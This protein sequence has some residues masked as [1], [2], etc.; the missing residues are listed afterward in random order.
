MTTSKFFARRTTANLGWD[1]IGIISSTFQ[2]VWAVWFLLPFDA[3]KIILAFN[4]TT[5]EN[6]WAMICLFVGF[7]H[8]YSIFS[9]SLRFRKIGCGLAIMFWTSCLVI[10][11]QQTLSSAIIPMYTTINVYMLVNLVWLFSL[12]KFGEYGRQ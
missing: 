6:L 12:N 3:F 7:I 9:P 2:I 5:T 10:L 4:F 8:L 11:L 1:I